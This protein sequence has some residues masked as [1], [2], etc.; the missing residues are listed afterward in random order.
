[1][2]EYY[3]YVPKWKNNEETDRHKQFK[4]RRK[5][6]WTY[7][8]DLRILWRKREPKFTSFHNHPKIIKYYVNAP[9]WMKSQEKFKLSKNA[10]IFLLTC[11]NELRISR[12]IRMKQ[13]LLIFL[14]SRKL[15]NITYNAQKL[16]KI[17]KHT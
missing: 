1:M 9:K 17:K 16:L 14:F 11:I 13:P 7:T 8:T 10:S 2:V 4:N 3:V 5:V 6:F 12:R 15:P